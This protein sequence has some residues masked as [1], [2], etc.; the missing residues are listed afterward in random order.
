MN[1]SKKMMASSRLIPL[2]LIFSAC[3]A[4]TQ[5]DYVPELAEQVTLASDDVVEPPQV[6]ERPTP[7]YPPELR[8]RG[9]EGLVVVKGIVGR[10]GRL[11]D[12]QVVR[13]ENDLLI[14][15]LLES[16]RQWRFRPAT[17][18]GKPVA[19]YYTVTQRLIID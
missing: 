19:T 8:G 5:T 3:T 15:P 9:I 1:L 11:R 16:L 12:V 7:S 13:A 17:V 10:D 14:P 18:N 4:T 6:L 2:L